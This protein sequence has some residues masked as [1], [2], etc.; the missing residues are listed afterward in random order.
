MTH[1]RRNEGYWY[2]GYLRLHV[3]SRVWYQFLMAPSLPSRIMP[4]AIAGAFSGCECFIQYCTIHLLTIVAQED[5][6]WISDWSFV[7]QRLYYWLLVKVLRPTRVL[8]TKQVI[9]ETFPEP[10]SW[11]GMEKQQTLTQQ[12]YTFTNQNKCRLLQHKINK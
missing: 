10:I 3:C 9:S 6:D 7:C 8:G 12:K 11:L 2:L 5:Q 1:L 4:T